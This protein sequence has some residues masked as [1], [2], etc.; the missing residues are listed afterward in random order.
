ML[1]LLNS[2]AIGFGVRINAPRSGRPIKLIHK[3]QIEHTTHA[4]LSNRA[5]PYLP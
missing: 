3:R 4:Q 1:D 2:F 5:S